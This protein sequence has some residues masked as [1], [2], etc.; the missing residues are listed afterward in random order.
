MVAFWGLF[1]LLGYGCLGG[2]VNFVGGLLGDSNP[3]FVK[4]FPLLGELDLARVICLAVLA[5]GGFLIHRMISKPKAA[6]MLVE[7]EGEMRKVTWPSSSE[8]VQGALA[9]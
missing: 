3:V 9:V 2:L 1:L 5:A 6:E 8:T 7:T 4:P